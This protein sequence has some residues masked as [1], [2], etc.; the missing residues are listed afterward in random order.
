MGTKK[1]KRVVIDTNVVISGL[2]FAGIP[3]QIVS[4]WKSGAIQ[5]LVSAEILQEYLKVLSYPRFNLSEQ[6]ISY[7]I[8]HE[9][10]PYFE[11][12]EIRGKTTKSTVI[13]EDPSD[14]KF[15]YCAL[16]GNAEVIISGDRHLLE[17]GSFKQI[18][19]ENP[20]HFLNHICKS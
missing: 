18:K 6:E 15:I 3:G 7:L 11:V 5:A 13:T 4:L 12:V 8:Y 10:L 14:D 1:I 17:L 2:L 19:I 16:A 9:I 20:T